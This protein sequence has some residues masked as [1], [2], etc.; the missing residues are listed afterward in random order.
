[1]LYSKYIACGVLTI[2]KHGFTR[3]ALS[4]HFPCFLRAITRNDLSGDRRYP[5]FQ[6][7]NAIK[8]LLRRKTSMAQEFFRCF[9]KSHSKG[10][11]AEVDCKEK[12]ALQTVNPSPLKVFYGCAD[13][14]RRLCNELDKHLATLKNIGYITTWQEPEIQAGADR[15][16]ETLRNLDSSQIIILLLSAD[17]MGSQGYYA[18]II[19]RAFELHNAG[20]AQIIPVLLRPTDVQ[21]TPF[22][23][24]QILSNE[25][26]PVISTCRRNRD[27]AF[28]KVAKSIRLV[29]EQWRALE[30]HQKDAPTA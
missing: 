22:A 10:D 2:E 30:K 21:G 16:Q 7:A 19:P 23:H 3:K 12:T 6:S 8:K 17:F 26:K 15:E 9:H 20:Q 27:E 5:Y 28:L 24:M 29:V 4:Y 1:M 13:K 14:D 18:L 11:M 25:G